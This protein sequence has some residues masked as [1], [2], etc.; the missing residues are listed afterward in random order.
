MI[1]W[2]PEYPS[3][4]SNGVG[5]PASRAGGNWKVLLGTNCL[6]RLSSSQV[7]VQVGQPQSSP[8]FRSP[9]RY[10]YALN[11]LTRRAKVQ[12]NSTLGR[13]LPHTEAK[14]DI[15]RYHLGAWF[16]ILGSGFDRIQ[17]IDGFSGPGQYLGGEPGSPMLALNTVASHPYFPKF[18]QAGKQMDFL[19]VERDASFYASL[20]SRVQAREWPDVFKIDVQPGE[21][22]LI[23]NE[24]L[25][26]VGRARRQIPPTLLFVDPFGSS[27][28]SMNLLARLG[29][30]ER[31][32]MLINFNYL[33]LNRWLPDASKHTTVDSLYGSSRWRRALDLEGDERKYFLIK[34][35]GQALLEAG[36]RSTNFEMINNNNQTQ[37]YLF[38]GARHPRGME[39]MKQAMR[40]VSPDG[41]FRYSDRT[42][43]NQPMLMGMGMDEVYAQELADYLFTKYQ[44]EEVNKTSITEDDV[45]WHPRWINK[46]LTA[47]LRL[48]ENSNPPRIRD[49][50]NADSRRR[51]K[52]SFP[53]GCII[54]FAEYYSTPL[55]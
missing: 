15:L 34:E 39:V 46:D 33:D 47:A 16:P 36:W 48:L 11:L 43:P 51:Q 54:R 25:E 20:R 29:S 12:D 41:L 5:R 2:T 32:D 3:S 42:D 14:H 17:Y 55:F 1:A 6:V 21:F 35:Y 8:I 4:L 18:A 49:V 50:R 30:Y 31:I 10:K 37:Y 26:Q 40:S 13:I 38:F 22:E 24:I 52:N 9:P 53:D 28:F 7:Q 45:A 23:L 44:G 27:G 19:F